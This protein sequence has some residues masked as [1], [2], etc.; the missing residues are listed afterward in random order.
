MSLPAS[1]AILYV[2][3]KNGGRLTYPELVHKVAEVQ[4][5]LPLADKYEFK[6]CVIKKGDRHCTKRRG[7]LTEE[8]RKI[9][10]PYDSKLEEDICLLE[11]NGFVNVEY[12]LCPEEFDTLYECEHTHITL[13]D[14][15]KEIVQKLINKVEY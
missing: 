7:A 9:A 13:T 2:L 10:Q 5:K 14:R 6:W 1:F 12:G 8:E 4:D 15:G 3:Y 11:S